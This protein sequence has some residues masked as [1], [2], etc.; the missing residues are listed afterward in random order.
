VLNGFRQYKRRQ[1][2][3]YGIKESEKDR[4]KS[5]EERKSYI[6]KNLTLDIAD[7]VKEAEYHI[8][9]D[10][11]TDSFYLQVKGI[12]YKDTYL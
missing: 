8:G 1:S 7:E 3:V 5:K 12:I 4:M 10:F 9:Y 11:M 2:F 6:C